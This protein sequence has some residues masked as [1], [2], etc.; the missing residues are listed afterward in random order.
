MCYC[1]ERN[2][3]QIVVL[4]FQDAV[5]RIKQ[6]FNKEFSTVYEKKEQEIAKIKDKNK[7]I[8]KII[9]D[10]ELDNEIYEPE[11]GVIEK[12]EKLLFVEDSEVS[13]KELH[14]NH[15]KDTG[16]CTNEI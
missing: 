1:K 7:R 3:F 2:S 8:R 9:E 12:P 6:N 4:T 16:F 11:L 10:L 5:H 15:S 14:F 13:E